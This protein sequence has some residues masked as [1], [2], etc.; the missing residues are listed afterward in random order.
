[1]F[2]SWVSIWDTRT[3]R[4]NLPQTPMIDSLTKIWLTE[5]QDFETKLEKSYVFRVN[6]R[7][8]TVIL[9]KKQNTLI[10]GGGGGGV[11]VEKIG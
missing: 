10:M 1:M 7:Q 3:V 8:N 11:D 5:G 4:G 2:G 6:S 9:I